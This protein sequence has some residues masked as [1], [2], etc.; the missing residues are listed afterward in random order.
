MP[1]FLERN[2]NIS[3]RLPQSK[4]RLT[5]QYDQTNYNTK[6]RNLAQEDSWGNRAKLCIRCY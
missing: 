6:S 3:T 4:S 2:K 1:L 5:C